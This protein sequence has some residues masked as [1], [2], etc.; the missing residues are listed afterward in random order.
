MKLF[1]FIPIKCFDKIINHLFVHKIIFKIHIVID[2]LI[3]YLMMLNVNVFD[4]FMM[5]RVFDEND[6][7]LI[8]IEDNNHLK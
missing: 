7:V 5:L 4:S 3:S 2:N 8:I 6:N 1:E